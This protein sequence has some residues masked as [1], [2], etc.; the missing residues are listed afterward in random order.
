MQQYPIAANAKAI[1]AKL[2]AKAP[3]VQLIGR[4]T[5]FF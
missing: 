4:Q 1:F 5:N 2:S 3:Q